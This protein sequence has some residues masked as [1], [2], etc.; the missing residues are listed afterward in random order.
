MSGG[1]G[2]AGYVGKPDRRDGAIDRIFA[3]D[4]NDVEAA[5]WA[6]AGR[7]EAAVEWSEVLPD[8]QTFVLL[9]VDDDRIRVEV[10]RP[11]SAATGAAQVGQ[12]VRVRAEAG[13]HGD[14]AR[15][16]TVVR[17]IERR[18]ADLRGVETAPLR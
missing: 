12:V 14:R 5:V 17:E 3:G 18:L 9:V 16:E 7:V 15:A 8:R 13:F 4:W 2:G 6:V 1:C 11:E 10:T